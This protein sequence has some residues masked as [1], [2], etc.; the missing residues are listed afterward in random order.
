MV[1]SDKCVAYVTEE[2]LKSAVN[3]CGK[4]QLNI[5]RWMNRLTSA[6]IFKYSTSDCITKQSIPWLN[7]IQMCN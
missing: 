1:S 3:P 2:F 5:V 4:D 6:E 7:D